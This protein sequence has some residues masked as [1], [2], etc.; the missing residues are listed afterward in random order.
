MRGND[1]QPVVLFQIVDGLAHRGMP[2][3]D[4]NFVNFALKPVGAL[5]V[6]EQ[7]PSFTAVLA[8]A[9]GQNQVSEN[10]KVKNAGRHQRKAYRG[11]VKQ[12]VSLHL[13]I[14]RQRSVDTD[15]QVI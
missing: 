8:C 7:R 1:L 5:K 4:G 11:H 10:D 9:T 15:D 2:G 6:V 13:L 14:G 12:P 3:R